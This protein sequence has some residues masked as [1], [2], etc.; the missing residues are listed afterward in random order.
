VGRIDDLAIT[1]TRGTG[2]ARGQKTDGVVARLRRLHERA[3][4]PPAGG[5]S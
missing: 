2:G 3:T 1:R 5:P 4:S